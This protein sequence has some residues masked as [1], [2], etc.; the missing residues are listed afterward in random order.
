MLAE[1]DDVLVRRLRVVLRRRLQ[2]RGGADRAPTR[3]PRG[4]RRAAASCPARAR[5]LAS[6]RQSTSY[7]V[8]VVRSAS[9]AFTSAGGF[10]PSI[11][12]S[13]AR[14]ASSPMNAA[15]LPGTSSF[16]SRPRWI[17]TTSNDAAKWSVSGACGAS[18]KSNVFSHA[19]RGFFP[20]ATMIA[21]SACASGG[22]C[23]KCGTGRS[24]QYWSSNSER[25]LRRAG[26]DDYGVERRRGEDG[27]EARLEIGDV[28]LVK[29]R[30]LSEVHRGGL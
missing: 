25:F 13:A 28:V 15:R 18:Q 12:Q 4:T 17:W 22:Q 23:W 11:A 14:E 19:S 9:S 8:F 21:Q 29:V 5:R 16:T 27:F 26:V 7:G 20:L 30:E 10:T 3:R 1:R 2:V 24:G 6:A